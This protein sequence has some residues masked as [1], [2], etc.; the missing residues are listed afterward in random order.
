MARTRFTHGPELPAVRSGTALVTG[1]S[2]GIGWAT[3]EKLR[4][5]GFTVYGTSRRGADAPHPEGITMVP[6]VGDDLESVRE[7]V[8]ATGPVDVLVANHGESQSGAFEELPPD[9]LE[10]VFRVN[11]LSQVQLA[12]LVLPGMRASGRG[13]IVFVGSMLGSM[14]LP[15]RSSYVA[16]KAAV[17]GFGQSLRGEVAQFGIGV[18]V[19]EPGSI[20]TGISQRRTKYGADG[21][22]GQDMSTMISRLDANEAKGITADQVADVIV[23][24]ILADRPKAYRARGSF[25]RVVGP[26]R[27][28]LPVQGTLDLM[29]RFHGL[30]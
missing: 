29:K 5:A 8:E 12:Q 27:R 11:V 9:A 3:A 26:L 10:R 14:P 18:S 17:S 7:A 24:E 6:L 2:S 19:V 16:T 1:A 28:I 21:P 30:R 4:D 23:E 15:Y 13:R 25:A 22:Y 20:N